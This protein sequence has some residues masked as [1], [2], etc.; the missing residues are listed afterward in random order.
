MWPPPNWEEIVVT[1]EWI[2]ASRR[3][4]INELYKWVNKQPGGNYHIHGNDHGDFAFRFENPS[5]AT[6]FSLHIPE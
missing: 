2:M 5:D 6:W 3:H 4:D 1:W